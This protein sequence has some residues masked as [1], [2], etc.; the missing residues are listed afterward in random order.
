[1]MAK[2]TALSVENAK[3]GK[4]EKGETVRREIPDGGCAGLYLVVQPSGH[5]S[6]AARFRIG[7]EPKKLT[8]PATTL[9]D[10][11][12][13]TTEALRQAKAGNDPCEA[14]QRAKEE[15]GVAAA[16]TFAAVAQ[17]YLDSKPVKALR[18][19]KQVSDMLRRLAMPEIGAMPIAD[20]KRKRVIAMLDHIEEHNGAVAADR[21]LS[22]VAQVLKFQAKRDDD[23]VY[24]LI[25]GMRKKSSVIRQRK[26]D[27]A[28][29]RAVWGTGDPFV[30]FLL[31][32][33]ARRNEAADLMWAELSPDG[34][35]W[36]L[37][38]AKNKGKVDLVRPLSIATMALLATLPRHGEYVFGTDRPFRSFSHLAKVIRTKS[39]TTGWRLHDLRRTSRTLMSRGGANSEHAERCLGHRIGNSVTQAYDCWEYL[40]EKRRVYETLA[41]LLGR[42]TN[43]TSNVIPMRA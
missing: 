12:V 38:A 9:A 26:L 15:R 34:T 28:E 22:A 2:L 25:E 7:G 13:Q 32:T 24:P 35:S 5:K 4:N 11:R 30:K 23:Y 42:I 40:E 8:L 27:D 14:K 41:G 37:P 33:A 6:F 17:L 20:V 3:P 16:N 31:L 39:K 21:V 10:A 29:I 18:S 1:M 43:P 36:L 19:Y